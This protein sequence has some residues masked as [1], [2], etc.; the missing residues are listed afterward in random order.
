MAPE[1]GWGRLITEYQETI[2]TYFFQAFTSCLETGEFMHVYNTL[3]VL[4][5]LSPV[6]P[7]AAVASHSGT[8]LSE[9]LSAFLARE[10]RQDLKT[11]G[12]SLSFPDPS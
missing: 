12:K 7:L 6:F 1:T 11:L 4:G 10:T 8:K 2:T 3:K 5:E 9:A